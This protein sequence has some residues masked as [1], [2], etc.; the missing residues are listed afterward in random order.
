ML[1]GFTIVGIK[2]RQML[3]WR[4]YDLSVT[5]YIQVVQLEEQI[6]RVLRA[7]SKMSELILNRKKRC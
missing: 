5:L 7:L 3:D 2:S 1:K 4:K 6:Y